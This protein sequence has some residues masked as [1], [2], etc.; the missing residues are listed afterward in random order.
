[1]ILVVPSVAIPMSYKATVRCTLPTVAH[2][3]PVDAMVK[4]RF[5]PTVY[6]QMGFKNRCFHLGHHDK[7]VYA[8]CFQFGGGSDEGWLM[9][10][11]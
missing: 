3:T 2:D 11:N 1:M 6:C 5:P 8:P 10:T 9:S 7:C 4:S